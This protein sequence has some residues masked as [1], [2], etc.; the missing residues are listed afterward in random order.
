MS[1]SVAHT[2]LCYD[3]LPNLIDEKEEVSL[4]VQ[5]V[6]KMCCGLVAEE[7]ISSSFVEAASLK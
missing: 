3:S 7:V 2:N 1:F 6:L 4:L 5:A